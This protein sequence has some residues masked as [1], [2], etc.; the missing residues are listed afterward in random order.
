MLSQGQHM[1]ETLSVDQTQHY[2]VLVVNQTN[3]L[4]ITTWW[5][6]IFY[7][8]VWHKAISMERLE[9]IDLSTW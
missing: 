4:I 5:E 9:R 3:F 8:L 7:A 1:Y 2:T 6:I